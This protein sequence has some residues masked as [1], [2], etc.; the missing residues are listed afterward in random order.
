[1]FNL[2]LFL[3]KTSSLTHSWSVFLLT[4]SFTTHIL[5]FHSNSSSH[6]LTLLLTYSL[7]HLIMN[8][9][10]QPIQSHTSDLTP[11]QCMFIEQ[12]PLPPQ[13]SH[14]VPQPH[15]PPS[16]HAPVRACTL[17]VPRNDGRSLIVHVHFMWANDP[18][19]IVHNFN[20]LS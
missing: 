6:W 17:R 13:Q 20:Y 1:M 5:F 4:Y 7:H 10:E 2:S 8:N 16:I 15:Q 12:T 9:S 14:L 18:R 3:I 19:V 11:F